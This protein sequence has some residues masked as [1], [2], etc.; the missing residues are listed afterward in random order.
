M[1]EWLI[2]DAEYRNEYFEAID[3]ASNLGEELLAQVSIPEFWPMSREYHES[4]KRLAILGQETKG[5][6]QSLGSMTKWE[7]FVTSL[8]GGVAFDYAN[9]TP[10]AQSPFWVAF[11]EL[12]ERKQVPAPRGAWWSNIMKVQRVAD[13]EASI[14]CLTREQQEKVLE[15]QKSL[16]SAE[17][18]FAKPQNMVCFTGPNY[19]FALKSMFPDLQLSE[20]A[21][22]SE[23]E[24][25]VGY[26]PSLSCTVARTYHPG[27]LRRKNK[28]HLVAEV[29]SRLQ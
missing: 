2:D 4:V 29:A 15:W 8:G 27:Y 12:C 25:M 1:K 23:N 22:F 5:V 21:G 6:S 18:R 10:G 14:L 26:I 24:L 19:D 3:R 7:A 9:G 17:M 20:V 28:W 11:R 16:F 13:E